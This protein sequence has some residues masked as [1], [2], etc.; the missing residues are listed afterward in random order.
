MQRVDRKNNQPNRKC[1]HA[2]AE[3]RDDKHEQ[4]SGAFVQDRSY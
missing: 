4:L 1:K 2:D 3:T